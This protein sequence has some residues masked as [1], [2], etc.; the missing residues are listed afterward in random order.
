MP[1]IFD[2]S[3]LRRWF[4]PAL[5]S[6][7]YSVAAVIAYASQARAA[8]AQL[9][10]ITYDS[11]VS[12]WGPGPEVEKRFEKICQCDLVFIGAGD[13]AALLTRLRLQGKNSE[14]DIVLGLDNNLM[15]EAAKSGLF[16]EHGLNNHNNLP[17]EFDD[18][19]FMPYDWGWFSFVY[20]KN[21]LTIPPE[22]FDELAKSDLK[23]IIEDPRSSTPGLGLLAWVKTA[24][25]DKSTQIWQN[26]SDNIVTVTPSWS[27]AYGLFLEGEADMVL[28]Y[29]TSPAYHLIA[30]Q[31]DSKAAAVF[32]E[33]H[34]LQVEVAGIVKNTDQ[35]EL[36][37]SF[38]RFMKSDQFQSLIP[39][40]NWMYPALTPK[41]GLP[42]GFDRFRPQKS[43]LMAADEFG[44]IRAE[45]IEEWREA[46]SK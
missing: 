45:M 27:E 21:T 23:I 44:T 22:N 5:C 33:G 41:A 25:G 26:L 29:S 4:V 40:T 1:W 20:D 39:T 14:A 16:Q 24:Y 34:Y 42:E 30:E 37:Q 19:V 2:S 6:A 9:I 10:V 35:P 43:L 28:S 31:D 3:F 36:A 13:G 11:F 38:M 32:D 7:L 12:Q 8:P 46:L 17:I 15:S 18:P